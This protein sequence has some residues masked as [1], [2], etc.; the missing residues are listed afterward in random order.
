[1][2][3]LWWQN[4]II[5]ELYVDKFAGSFS[6]LTGR[7]EYLSDLGIN[8]IWVLPHY[9]SPM[10]DG[11]YD[12][13]DYR[14]VRAGLGTID[15][16]REFVLIAHKSGI[17]VIVDLVLNHTSTQHPWFLEASSLKESPRRNYY[18]WSQ[19]ASELSK[20]INAFPQ[21]K[22]SNWIY[23]AHLNEYYYSTFYPEQ[24]D[25]DWTNQEVVAEFKDIMRYWLDMGVDGFRLD[26]VSHLSKKEG[27]SCKNLPEVHEIVKQFRKFVDTN[28]PGRILIGEATGYPGEVKPYFGKGDEF[29]LLFNFFLTEKLFLLFAKNEVGR[30]HDVVSAMA[31]I[32]EGCGWISFLTNHDA[33][34]VHELPEADQRVVI[35]YID[36]ARRFGFEPGLSSALRLMSATQG[37]ERLLREMY[38]ILFSLDGPHSIYYGEEIGMVNAQL[39]T[40]PL[41]AREYIRASFDWQSAK[42][43]EANAQSLLHFVRR[44]VKMSTKVD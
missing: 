22:S 17:R 28:Y 18:L 36:P 13:S 11:G 42:N 12:V 4:L 38:E 7:L 15:D 5:Y 30:L 9:P 1:M 31:D 14:S 20:G 10:V 37:D 16:F 43:Q 40:R 3:D 35:D 32:P 44:L 21:L 27:T 6:G 41:D 8:C 2:S 25:L 39:S 26:A 29:H 34:S 33:T 24:A 23:N 19:D